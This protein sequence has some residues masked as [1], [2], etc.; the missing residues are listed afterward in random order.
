VG[1]RAGDRVEVDGRPPEL[2]RTAHATDAAPAP[3][4][5][6]R[7]SRP[8]PQTEDNDLIVE[9]EGRESHKDTGGDAVPCSCW[10]RRTG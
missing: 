10:M 5:G 3:D 9:L 7:W 8:V 6:A 4:A 1:E 2:Y